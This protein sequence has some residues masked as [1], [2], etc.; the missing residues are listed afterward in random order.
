MIHPVFISIAKQP[1]LFLEHV[2]A[3]AELASAEADE[4]GQR[5]K[6]RAVLSAAAAVAF[7]LGLA[8]AGAAGL[9]VAAIPLQAM[10]MPW[11][12]LAIPATPLLVGCALVWRVR[13]LAR[14][15]AFEALRQQVAQDLATLKILDTQ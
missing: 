1:G 8:L 3:Y 5:W 7:A 6:Q 14:P 13:S 2:D 4:W 9:I 10:P 12:L 11:L 15:V